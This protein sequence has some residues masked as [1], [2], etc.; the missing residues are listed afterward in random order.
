MKLIQLNAWGGRL[1]PQI[2]DLMSKELPD[3]LCLQE[4]ISF[5]GE[6]TG[7]FIT[8][9]MLQKE[10]D[11][12]YVAFSPVFSFD[13]MNG[14]ARFGNAVL[15]RFPLVSVETVFTYLEHKE[16]FVWGEH[17]SNMRNFVHVV[18]DVKGT[19]CNV[20]SHHGFWV[21][22]HKKGNDETKRQMQL[23]ADYSKDL[24]GP[25]I[26]AGDFN[27]E[28]TSESLKPLNQLY[29]NLS[30]KY[31]LKTTRTDLT[32]KT[33][34]CDYVFVNDPVHVQSFTALDKVAS[35]HKALALEF[36]L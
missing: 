28:P 23:L 22:E 30:T 10:F 34:T 16:N 33:E 17:S 21:P 29:N 32:Y 31:K 12:P 19:H 35:D 11:L 14:T 2:R 1:E 9:E 36:K 3:I 4:V 8:I 13:F 18:I 5:A 24:S 7:L 26:L 15:S 6:G 27:L 20:L 25:V